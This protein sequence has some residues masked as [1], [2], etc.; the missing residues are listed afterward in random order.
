MLPH[1]RE[2]GGATKLNRHGQLWD[3]NSMQANLKLD[4]SRCS[5][6][7]HGCR[8]L[9]PDL[10]VCTLKVN[11]GKDKEKSMDDPSSK[12][13]KSRFVMLPIDGGGLT[14]IRYT[15][16]LRHVGVGGAGQIEAVGNGSSCRSV[17]AT[18]LVSVARCLWQV[19]L[20]RRK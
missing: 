12:S 5:L 18:Q 16:C 9:P 20:A 8:W 10:M 11:I 13:F 14:P 3:V 1:P 19:F 6:N 15:G 2:P 7:H 17:A 4:R